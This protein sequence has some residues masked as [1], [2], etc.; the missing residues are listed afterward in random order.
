M[1]RPKRAG[2]VAQTILYNAIRNRWFQS[3]AFRFEPKRAHESKIVGGSDIEK[4]S[5]GD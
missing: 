2:N 3:V 5:N 1:P 4:M